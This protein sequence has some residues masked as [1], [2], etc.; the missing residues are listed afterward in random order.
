MT[1]TFRIMK[2]I[3]QR[4]VMGLL[5]YILLYILCV[6]DINKDMKDGCIRGGKLGKDRVL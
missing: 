3:T 5:L 4:C 1:S 2:E 6:V